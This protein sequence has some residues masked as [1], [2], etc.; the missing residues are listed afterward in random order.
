MQNI[1]GYTGRHLY[2]VSETSLH[3]SLQGLEFYLWS[4]R[5]KIVFPCSPFSFVVVSPVRHQVY[6][7]N[8]VLLSTADPRL[9]KWLE[10]CEL[11]QHRFQNRVTL[12]VAYLYFVKFNCRLCFIT[13]GNG[14]DDSNNFNDNSDIPAN[15]NFF[16]V[17]AQCF[18]KYIY[19]PI[20]TVA[21]FYFRR[22][23]LLML[24]PRSW[25]YA[26]LPVLFKY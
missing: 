24:K 15:I 21:F 13:S 26:R 10:F 8:L 20:Y 5:F 4:A 22:L 7:E 2:S 3:L 6:M 18:C 1:S 14:K 12:S 17:R 19:A 25:K 23:F 11:Y 9:F 16:S